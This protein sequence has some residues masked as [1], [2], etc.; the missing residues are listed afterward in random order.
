MGFEKFYGFIG[1]ETDQW[2]P[3]L[4]QDNQFIETPHR[5]G[6]HLTEDLVDHTI[7]YIR[8]QQQV[9]TGRPFFAYLALGTAHAPLH[10]P[11]AYIEKY[12]GRFDMGWDEARNQIIERQKGMGLF[13]R[14]TDLPPRNPGV[15]PWSD[16]SSDQKTVYTRL[17]EVF[18]AYLDHADHNL[19]RL[20]AAL[21]EMKIRDNTLIIVLSDNG[22]SQEGLQN[23]TA[24]TDRYRNYTPDTIQEIIGLL[25]SS[26]VPKPIRII[27]WAGRWRVTRR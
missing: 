21:D 26:A 11:K 8:D 2:A 9:S 25:T 12:K 6:Y 15:S 5:E 4:V 14:N 13:P 3:L 7:A 19:G 22:A 18:A 16:L 10:A 23:G 27:R 17:Q 20:F 1:G 24:N